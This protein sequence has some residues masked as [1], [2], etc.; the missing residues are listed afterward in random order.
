MR[1]LTTDL[2]KVTTELNKLR[3]KN[4]SLKGKISKI[5]TKLNDSEVDTNSG[6]PCKTSQSPQGYS[7]LERFFHPTPDRDNSQAEGPQEEDD[8]EELA[9]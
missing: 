7:M 9:I 2:N 5:E 6:G 3:S 4:S 1:G 8:E